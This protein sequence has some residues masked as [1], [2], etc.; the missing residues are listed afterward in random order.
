MQ[1]DHYLFYRDQ[2]ENTEYTRERYCEPYIECRW[3]E[4]ITIIKNRKESPNRK[5]VQEK[6]AEE[7]IH[8]LIAT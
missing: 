8:I 4:N 7:Q 2:N 6:E 5:I 3:M 1:E